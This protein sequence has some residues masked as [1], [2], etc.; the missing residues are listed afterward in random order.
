MRRTVFCAEVN[1]GLYTKE[2]FAKMIDYTLLRPD[3]TREDVERFAMEAK[4]YHFAAAYVF[5]C[6]VKLV[7]DLLNESD[8]K[9]GSVVGFPYGANNRATK[10][11]EARALLELGAREL[12]MVINIGRLK[13]K[14]YTAVRR[15][16]EEVAASV[17]RTELTRDKRSALLKVIIE[18]GYLTREEKEI[19]CQIAVD[20][21]ADFVKTSTGVGPSGA[22]AEDVRLMRRIVGPEMGVKAAGGIA[23]VDTALLMLDSGANRIGT[24]RGVL[25]VNAYEPPP[26]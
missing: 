13:S 6:W 1:P 2:Q 10:V 8:V 16:I 25:L 5:P 3:A 20:A 7:V 12:D 26:R 22:T 4:E 17:R 15:E 23:D 21:G 19:A 14:D 11:F 9:V 18:T 24:S